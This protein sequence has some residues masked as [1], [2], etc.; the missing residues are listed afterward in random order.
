VTGTNIFG[1]DPQLGPL[2]NN[3]TANG[4]VEPT[5][6]R[7]LAPTSPAIDRGS[8]AF[9]TTDQRGFQRARDLSGAPNATVHGSDQYDHPDASDIGAY[10]LQPG[11]SP[12]VSSLSPTHGTAAGGTVVAINGSGLGSA[13]SVRFG[14]ANASFTVVSSTRINATSPGGSGKV[15]VTVSTPFGTSSAAGSGNDF[16]Y[17][18]VPAGPAPAA[19]GG[20]VT[21]GQASGDD[22]PPECQGREATIYSRARHGRTLTGTARRDVIVGTPGDDTIQS[23]GGN[24]V[25]CAGGGKDTVKGGDGND[26][27][28]GE[29]GRDLLLGQVGDDHLYGEAA[30]DICV[31][32]SGQDGKHGC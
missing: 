12:V 24:D 21:S 17:D 13:T 16:D 19:G 11:P 15:D 26:R 18:P 10:E 2:T 23:G 5:L 4:D 14:S 7:A 20:P 8:Q 31:G 25:V 9:Y 28:Y 27:L 1:L 22:G 6:T 29:G 32:G 30:R 3:G